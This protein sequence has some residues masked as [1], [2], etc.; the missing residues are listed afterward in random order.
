M[1]LEVNIWTNHYLLSEG[2]WI[3]LLKYY[4]RKYLIFSFNILSENLN[5]AYTDSIMKH[6]L[7]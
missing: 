5:T 3:I 6:P 2:N 1:N 7:Q 4:V